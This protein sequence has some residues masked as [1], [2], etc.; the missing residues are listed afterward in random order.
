MITGFTQVVAV[1]GHPINQVKSPE[2]FNRYFAQ[3]QMDSVMIPIDIEPDAVAGYL[4]ALRGWKNMSG[5]LVTVPHKQR[6]AA[7]LDELSPRAM[8]LNAVNV[9]RKLPDGRLKGDMLDGVGFLLAAKNIIFSHQVR[10]PCFLAVA[11]SEVPLHGGFVK[12]VRLILPFMIKI[13]QCN[14]VSLIVLP[15]ISR[16]FISLHYQKLYRILI[17]LLMVLLPEWW[18]LILYPSRQRYWKH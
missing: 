15:H 1:I 3:Q 12:Q 14:R 18:A 6:V 7:L 17:S 10:K 16:M 9:V 8:H 5:V 11:V 4:N 13:R 2:N